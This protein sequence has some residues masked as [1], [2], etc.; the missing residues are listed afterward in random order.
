[1]SDFFKMIERL[2]GRHDQH[3][4]K[5]DVIIAGLKD[6]KETIMNAVL[7]LQGEI[8]VLHADVAAQKTAI[9]SAVVLL[10]GIQARIDAAVA[11]A[12]ANGATQQQ[13]ADIAQVSA[14]IESGTSQLAAAVVANTPAPVGTTSA[15]AATG[16]GTTTSGA[17]TS[18]G[19]TPTPTTT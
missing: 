16:G 19:G 11:K 15:P 9:A 6:M 17:T 12:I 14:D 18:S 13:L 10:N 3:D 5:L 4:A 7:T 2:F 8:G 1:M